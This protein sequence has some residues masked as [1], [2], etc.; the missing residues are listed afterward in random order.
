MT[1]LYEITGELKNTLQ[2][3]E[4]LDLDEQTIKDTLE[5]IELEFDDKVVSIAKFIKNLESTAE[6]IKQAE[7]EMSKRRKSLENKAMKIKDYV[8]NNMQTIGKTKIQ[9]P[10][11]DVTIRKNPASVVVEDIDQIPAKYFVMPEVEP[12]LDKKAVKAAIE[13]GE[14][15][16]G[17]FIQNTTSLQIK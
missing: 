13:S 16:K 7:T 6:A 17:A 4:S 15:V 3:L 2:T 5:G 1:A 10:F 12:Q 11:F 8:V 9:S 14:V